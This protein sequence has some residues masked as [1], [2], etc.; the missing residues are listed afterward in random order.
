[1]ARG[2]TPIVVLVV[3]ALVVVYA[4]EGQEQ[5]PLGQCLV[6]C[7]EKVLTCAANCGVKGGKTSCYQR[8]GSGDI[9]C[10]EY[11]LGIKT[12]PPANRNS[13]TFEA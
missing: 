2:S 11:C 3:V 7:G 5:E 12:P 10:V 6:T 8:C 9:G 1:M 4:V 13:A